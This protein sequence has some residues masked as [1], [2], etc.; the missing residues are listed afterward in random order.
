MRAQLLRHALNLQLLP[1]LAQG[2]GV[3]LREKVGHKLVLAADHLARQLDGVLAAREADELRGDGPALVDK[4]VEGVLPVGAGLPEVHLARLERQLAAVDAHALAVALHVQLLHVRGEAEQGLGVGQDGAALV[5]Q[6]GGVPDAQ[7][8]HQHGDVL[9]QGRCGEVL[10]DVACARQELL[11]DLEAE[12][13]GEGQ[14]AHGGADRVSA[15]HPVP[16]AEDVGRVYT[17]L[18]DQRHGGRGGHYVLADDLLGC[19]ALDAI[20]QPLAEGAGVEHGLGR[21]EGLGHH[22]HQRLL[23]VQPLRGSRDVHGVHVGQEAQRAPLRHL[24]G[25]GHW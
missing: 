5:A 14:H 22:H 10:V 6:E 13:E 21:G 4:L 18:R 8:A 7:Q 25:L 17:E 19:R 20:Q 24:G 11:Q 2:Q 23:W 16:E 3:G 12:D 15:T 9:A 1:R